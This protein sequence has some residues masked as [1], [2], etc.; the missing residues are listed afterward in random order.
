MEKHHAVASAYACRFLLCKGG[1]ALE[2]VTSYEYKD[3]Y[4]E[5]L[6]GF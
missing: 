5:E 2:C 4:K 1:E 6:N 3:K